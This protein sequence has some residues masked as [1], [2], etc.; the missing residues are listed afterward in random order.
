MNIEV[1]DLR[2]GDRF[3]ATDSIAGTFGPTE[4]LVL[5]LSLGGAKVSHPQPVRIGTRARLTF[6]RGDVA[7]SVQGHV[8]WSHLSRTGNGMAYH[9]GIQLEGVE[10]HYALAINS[11]IRAAIL[12]KD[13][14][15][16]ERKRERLLEREQARKTLSRP[17]PTA[18]TIE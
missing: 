3:V 18:G 6:K 4:I 5:D 12:Q 13:V 2:K 17:I 8:V 9:S 10:A 16:L 15:S 11:L 7:A 1:T 14:G